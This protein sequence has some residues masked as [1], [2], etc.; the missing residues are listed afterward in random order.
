MSKDGPPI[1]GGYRYGS[2]N[3]FRARLPASAINPRRIV[4][5]ADSKARKSLSDFAAYPVRTKSIGKPLPTTQGVSLRRAAALRRIAE[6]EQ[7][8][9]VIKSVTLSEGKRYRLKMRFGGDSKSFRFC[10]EDLAL[11]LIRYSLP[12]GSCAQALMYY[13]LNGIRWYPW[14]SAELRSAG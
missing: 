14:R 5:E 1:S 13:R 11:G 7:Q 12:Y 9:N 4:T 2:L 10:E 3:A 6:L 8:E